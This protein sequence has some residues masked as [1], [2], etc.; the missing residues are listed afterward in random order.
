M[1]KLVLATSNKGKIVELEALLTPLTCIPQEAFGLSSPEETGLSFVENALLKARYASRL[2]KLPALADDSGLVVPAL[3]GEPGIYSARFAGKNASDEENITLLLSKL[4]HL[5]ESA[6]QAYFYCSLVLVEYANDPTPLIAQGK[7]FGT[8]ARKPCGKQGFG[9]DPIF[10]IDK[11]NCTAAELP[12]DIKN[13]LS[14]RAQ[15][16]EHLQQQ[17]NCHYHV[18]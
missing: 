10:F 4:D 14:H 16:L 2:T 12:L 11:L 1:K 6:R 18:S 7:F 8:I 3:Q 15:A 5:P 13:C 17:L 9:Y